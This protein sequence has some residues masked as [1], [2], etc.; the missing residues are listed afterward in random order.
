MAVKFLICGTLKAHLPYEKIY[1]VREKN[2]RLGLGL[3]GLH[4]WLLQRKLP[5][6]VSPELHRWLAVYEHHSNSVARKFVEHLGI[7]PCVAVR[8]VAP[9]GTISMLADTTSGIEPLFAVAY[10][11]RYLA[12]NKYKY[13]YKVDDIAKKLIERYG[14]NPEKIESAES[15]SRDYERRIKFQA[16]VQD[17]VDMSISSTINLPSS[18]FIEPKEFAGVVA[19]YAHRLRGLTVYPNGARGGQPL[20]EVPYHEVK[21]KLGEEFE[22]ASEVNDVCLI[23]GK[24]GFCGV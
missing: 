24:G 11:R 21:D 9:T 8:A 18:G 5:Y 10:K 1:A 22:E 16:D 7:S 13:Q 4:E 6:E 2:R 12:N 17:Y 19:R 15:L 14:M 3:M 23:T 20:T